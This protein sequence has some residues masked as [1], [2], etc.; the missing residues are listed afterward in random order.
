MATIDQYE[1]SQSGNE[2]QEFGRFMGERVFAIP[3]TELAALRPQYVP[4]ATGEA[5]TWP[6]HTGDDAAVLNRYWL[7]KE[8]PGRPN[9]AKVTCWYYTPKWRFPTQQ[10]PIRGI[11]T[12]TTM[13]DVERMLV[14]TVESGR[15]IE[16]PSAVAAEVDKGQYYKVVKGDN[17]VLSPKTAWRIS[18]LALVWDPN[19]VEGLVGKVNN[20]MIFYGHGPAGKVMF[21][22]ATAT[23]PLYDPEENTRSYWKVN[24][25]FIKDPSGFND[26]IKV[27]LMERKP[28]PK[29]V[30]DTGRYRDV[31][32]ERPVDSK[33]AAESR[34]IADAVNFSVFGDMLT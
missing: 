14:E 34:T 28:I 26:K 29:E 9:H 15:V 7:I 8:F 32:V 19:T 12:C 3:H 13:G 5:N 10:K 1:I 25:D 24:L 22:G 16:G 6:D 33:K 11:L 30:G 21:L 31:I 2:G 18:A 17:T 20:A 23:A 4:S 27:R